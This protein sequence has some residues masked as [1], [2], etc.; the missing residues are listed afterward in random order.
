MDGS[1]TKEEAAVIAEDAVSL[2]GARDRLQRE[3]ARRRAEQTLLRAKAA[4]I[5][6]ALQ[7][8]WRTKIFVKDRDQES[9]SHFGK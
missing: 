2:A 3:I 9:L 1:L 4:C 5:D 6:E 8:A 7:V